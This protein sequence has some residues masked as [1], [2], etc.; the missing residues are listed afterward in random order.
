MKNVE[1]AG[2]C[3]ASFYVLTRTA[4]KDQEGANGYVLMFAAT[5]DV[6][7]QIYSSDKKWTSVCSDPGFYDKIRTDKTEKTGGITSY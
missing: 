5:G 2:S 7:I 1:L 6:G 4:A 3:T